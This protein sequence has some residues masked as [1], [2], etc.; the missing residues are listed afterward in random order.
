MT[1]AIDPAFRPS[2][3]TPGALEAYEALLSA[4]FEA[5]AKFT[6]RALAWRYRDNPAGKVVGTDAWSGETLAAHYVT[7]PAQVRL[8]GRPARALLSLNTATHPDFQGRGLFVR[9]AEATYERAAAAGF[10]CVFGVANANSTPGFLR[11]LG[12]QLVE[13]LDAGILLAAPRRR[14]AAAL[15]FQ[16]EWSEAGLAWRLANPAGRY[17]TGRSGELAAA[18]SPTHLPLVSCA[19]FLQTT[20]Q[21]APRRGAPL[22]AQLF[23]GLDPRLRAG[24][25][26]LAPL[27]TRFRPSPLNLIYRPL[28]ASAPRTLDPDAVALSFLDFDPY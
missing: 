17:V 7:C 21:P 26:R 10:D 2:E 19:A 25:L 5:S 11:R 16:G 13:P 3:A 14:A 12:F 15:D 20:P 8:S 28:S 24:G 23:I 1:A 27:P 22:G 6:A 4:T 9:L 18:W